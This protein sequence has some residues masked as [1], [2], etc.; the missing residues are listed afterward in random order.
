V[1]ADGGVRAPSGVGVEI[2]VIVRGPDGQEIRHPASR[3]LPD[4]PGGAPLAAGLGA[5]PVEVEIRLAAP[6]A[7]AAEKAGAAGDGSGGGPARPGPGE[8]SG[9]PAN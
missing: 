4:R 5:G 7:P 8:E 6:A 1:D 3:L 9:G 2:E